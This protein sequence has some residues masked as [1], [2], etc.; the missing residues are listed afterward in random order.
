MALEWLQNG[1]S[2]S[3]SLQLKG[4]HFLPLLTCHEE[5]EI[6]GPPFLF[7]PVVFFHGC[8]RTNGKQ[9]SYN[10]LVFSQL[11]TVKILVYER[12]F[13]F[14]SFFQL[15]RTFC[16]TFYNT[17]S[18]AAPLIPLCWDWAKDSCTMLHCHSKLVTIGA[19]TVYSIGSIGLHLYDTTTFS[20]LIGK[21]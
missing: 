19:H 9:F 5:R 8:L 14:F 4:R 7:H 1:S 3:L 21:P 18:S 16:Y 6:G 12:F 10:L 20:M 15:V 17:N 2:C 11:I 13:L